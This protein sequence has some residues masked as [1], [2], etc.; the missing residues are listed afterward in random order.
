MPA[1][2]LKSR[3]A[4]VIGAHTPPDDMPLT[5]H[6]GNVVRLGEARPD[7]EG[8]IWADDGMLSAGW[9]P[10]DIIDAA[11]GRNEVTSEYCS[12]ELAVEPGQRVRLMW[13]DPRHRAWWCES[14]DSERGWVWS[15]NLQFDQDEG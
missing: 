2:L 5:L 4:T 12:A 6:P 14:S 8:Y 7:R 1:P 9:I 11:S 3:S 10:R 13:E 15:E